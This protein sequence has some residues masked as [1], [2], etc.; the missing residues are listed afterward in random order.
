MSARLGAVVATGTSIWLDDL[1][2]ERLMEAPNATSLSFLIK[3]EFVT[4]VTT[5]PIIFSQAISKSDLYAIEIADLAVSGLDIESIITKLTTDDVRNACD[6]FTDTFHKS[7]G[8]DGRVSIEVDPRLARDTEN[9]IAQGKSL[10]NLVNRPNLLIK[11]PA[12]VEGLPAITALIADGIS[13]NVTIIFSVERYKAVLNA[14][15]EGL[16]LRLSNGKPITEIHSV[17]SFFIS[18]VDSEVDNQLKSQSSPIATALLGKAAIANARL[19]YKEFL[20]VKASDRW[21]T[22]KNNGAHI[23]RPL[24]ASTGVKDKTYEDTRYVTELTGPDTVNTMPQGTLDAVKDH[25]VTRGDALTSGFESAEKDL[26]ALN[27]TGISMEEVAVK[28]E[29]EGIDK[30]VAPWIELIESV[31]KVASL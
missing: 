27:A 23:Q 31:K 1:S 7:N 21:K 25:G 14:F 16:E 5:N 6:L 26:E 22:L 4:G 8:I 10:W 17:A 3:N 19:A 29:R 15:M 9:T 18:R 11:V 20:N 28:L 2:R 30:F 13:V 24:W 12:T